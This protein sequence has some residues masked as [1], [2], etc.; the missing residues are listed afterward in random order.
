[1]TRKGYG[2]LDWRQLPGMVEAM[3]LLHARKGPATE[4]DRPTRTSSPR[5]VPP[6]Q[7]D[8]F[9]LGDENGEVPTR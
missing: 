6:G 2:A 3:R 7:L 5:R 1:M 9:K 8:L 4:G